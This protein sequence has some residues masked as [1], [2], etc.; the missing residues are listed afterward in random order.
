VAAGLD[1]GGLHAVLAVAGAH[2]ASA[3]FGTGRDSRPMLG[4]T[5]GK[6]GL[7]AETGLGARTITR[8][9]TFLRLAG[10]PAAARAVACLSELGAERL[11]L[12]A[13]HP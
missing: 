4:D 9:R 7:T 2:A 3:D 13:L 6:R 11:D 5:G 10:L 8:A 12:Q 1:F